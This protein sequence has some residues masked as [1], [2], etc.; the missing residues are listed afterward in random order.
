[1]ATEFKPEI[2]FHHPSEL[3]HQTVARICHT[4]L[5]RHRIF[6]RWDVKGI[7]GLV[8]SGFG[9]VQENVRQHYT[10]QGCEP[11]IHRTVDIITSDRPHGRILCQHGVLHA[12]WRPM[13]CC[14]AHGTNLRALLTASHCVT[15]RD[16]RV[17]LSS[18][19]TCWNQIQL[20]REWGSS[21]LMFTRSVECGAR[22]VILPAR[23]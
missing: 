14:E 10:Q 2:C 5:L 8:S 6:L 11:G 21:D 17:T 22:L 7:L 4:S 23:Y 13:Q 15:S 18:H 12:V 1:M 19:V 20:L 9:C 3:G 16:T